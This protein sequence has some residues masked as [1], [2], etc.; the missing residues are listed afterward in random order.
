M[1]QLLP[2]VFAERVERLMLGIEPRDAMR[3]GRIAKPIDVVLDGVPLDRSAAWIP[4]GPALAWDRLFGVPDAI[5]AL[6]RIPRHHSCRHALLFGSGMVAAVT[7]RLF[8]RQRRFAP[9]RI[10]YPL[11]ANIRIA[12]P[13]V[14]RPALYPGAAYDISDAVTGLRGRVTW[15]QP[16]SNEVPA[17]W[18]RVEAVINGQIVGRAH[19]DD[20][21]EF[22]LLLDSSA[23]GLGDLPTLLTAQ[24]TVFGPPARLPVPA[25][26]P[27]GDLP[28]EVLPADPDD[29]SPGQRLPPG[30]VSTVLCSRPVDFELGRLL[31]QQNKFFFNP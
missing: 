24:V 3:A 21:G 10:R 31:T 9:R 14:R 13:R 17:R 20:R 6:T 27:L 1:N 30:Y 23:G 18:V 5:G 26:D 22:L 7:I 2:E 8:D 28:L 4:V 25:N 16:G 15:N 12:S 11:P 19:G 29:I